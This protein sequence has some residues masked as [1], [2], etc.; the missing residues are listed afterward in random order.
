MYLIRKLCTGRIILF[1]SISLCF[2][3]IEAVPGFGHC[4]ATS[5]WHRVWPMYSTVPIKQMNGSGKLAQ[6]ER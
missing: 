3:R 4:H 5:T 2:I 6:R 1:P